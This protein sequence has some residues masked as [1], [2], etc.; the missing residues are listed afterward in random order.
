[1]LN[2]GRRLSV[3]GAAGI[4]IAIVIIACFII[5]NTYLQPSS[6]GNGIGTGKLTI[7]ITDKPV[8]LKTLNLTID[9]A[10]I[11]G[12]DEK[13]LDL[14]LTETPFYFN[15]L[16]LQGVQTTLCDENEIPAGNYTM[17]WM[18]VLTA[19]AT[20]IED[21]YLGELRVPSNVIKVLLHPHLQLESGEEATVLIDL[22]PEDLN[23]IAI[24]KTLNL[25]PVVKMTVS[26]S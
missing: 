14:N 9:W 1:M 11:K 20:N 23:S 17:I 10:K 26:S 24:S 7:L 21:E 3:Y 13:W 16:D 5:G 8:T 12:E 22:E 4:L 19:N 18:H 15:L 6:Q 2:N 25:R